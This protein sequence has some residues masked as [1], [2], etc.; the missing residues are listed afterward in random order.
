MGARGP[1]P[2]SR[3]VGR[4]RGQ[5]A[6]Q[7]QGSGRLLT[8][9]PPRRRCRLLRLVPGATGAP[10]GAGEPALP[11]VAAAAAISAFSGR[12]GGGCSRLQLE[13]APLRG[14]SSPRSAL[15]PP[16][17]A[18]PLR[19]PRAARA[20]EG[21]GRGGRGP[22]ETGERTH[23][24]RKVLDRCAPEPRVHP[25]RVPAV[26]AAGRGSGEDAG[27]VWRGRAWVSRR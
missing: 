4:G 22:G 19:P 7:L 15:P 5:R 12:E 6:A 25:G 9:R 24:P 27:A 23:T 21:E 14:R 10:S 20:R 3:R 13:R 11:S 8:Q 18:R 17:A 26:A 1:A 16:G 2:S